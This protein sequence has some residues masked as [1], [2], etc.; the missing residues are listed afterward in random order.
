M[1]NRNYCEEN[2]SKDMTDNREKEAI[3]K[4]NEKIR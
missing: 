4:E 3:F 2:V 1:N